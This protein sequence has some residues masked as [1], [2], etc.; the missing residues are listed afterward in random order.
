MNR[1]ITILVAIAI[2]ILLS[3]ARLQYTAT[4]LQ[5]NYPD[6]F[7]NRTFI[8]DSN[9]TTEEG[10]YLGRML[11]YETALSSNNTIACATCH[12]QELAFTDGKT[13]SA[14][15]DGTL[16]TRNTMSLVNLL[17]VR[18]FFW[19]GRTVGLEQQAVTPLTNVH[20]MA[21]SLE[22]S[23]AKLKQKKIYAPLFVRAF[24]TDDI[25][26]SKIIKA[27]A[28][29]ERTLVSANSKYDKYLRG[30]YQPT[31]S[32]S[33]GIALF[34]SNPNP[35]R[36]IRGAGCDHCH[37]GPKTFNELFHNNGWTVFQKMRAAN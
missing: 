12:K 19:D 33:N 5:I 7:G 2:V 31:T 24:G 23:A 22:V 34:Y 35:V 16:Q 26:G 30:A 17:W 28:Q 32:E 11:F 15:A 4:P 36:N 25:T 9:L 13:F 37:G 29:F 8:P 20:E 6:Y 27:L 21:Q 14:G 1:T 18:N 3:A 10:V